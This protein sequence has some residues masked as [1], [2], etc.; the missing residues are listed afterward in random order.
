MPAS[1]KASNDGLLPF[2]PLAKLMTVPAIGVAFVP[3]VM[4]ADNESRNK[5]VIINPGSLVTRFLNKLAGADKMLING[6]SGMFKLFT[7]STK[8]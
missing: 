2:I 5:L 4:Y 7:A 8:S 6:S 1:I 3:L